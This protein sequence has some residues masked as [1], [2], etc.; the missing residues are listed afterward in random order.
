MCAMYCNLTET[1]PER[2]VSFTYVSVPTRRRGGVT[3]NGVAA[4]GLAAAFD[5]SL[6]ASIQRQHERRREVRRSAND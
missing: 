6:T 1:T 2:T 3:G 5:M 4:L